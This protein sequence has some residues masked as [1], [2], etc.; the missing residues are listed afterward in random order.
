MAV[1]SMRI[2]NDF[3]DPEKERRKRVREAKLKMAEER[4]EKV[5]NNGGN[6]FASWDKTGN[7]AKAK[8]NKPPKSPKPPEREI[9]RVDLNIREVVE[10]LKKILNPGSG[11]RSTGGEGVD[12]RDWDS[13]SGN[14]GKDVPFISWE[15]SSA[16]YSSDPRRPI[17]DNMKKAK[18]E[19]SEKVRSQREKGVED[20]EKNGSKQG[21]NSSG[22][23]VG[24]GPEDNKLLCGSSYASSPGMS[25]SGDGSQSLSYSSSSFS[26]ASGP[27]GDGRDRDF[28]NKEPKIKVESS[29]KVDK[30][31]DRKPGSRAVAALIKKN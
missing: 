29:F 15:K 24:K 13:D 27:R 26:V 21:G 6:G 2:D 30:P 16:P 23:S 5:G 28:S 22:E 11:P 14:T 4:N 20:K 25:G 7:G 3:D 31:T 1:H 12:I 19:R 8:N 18:E 10:L 17:K 9:V